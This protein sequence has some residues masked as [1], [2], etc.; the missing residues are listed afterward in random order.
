MVSD[1]HGRGRA[2]EEKYRKMHDE[3]NRGK[4]DGNVDRLE[5]AMDTKT[6]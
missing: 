1:T 3:K 2:D 5:N 4:E 6:L